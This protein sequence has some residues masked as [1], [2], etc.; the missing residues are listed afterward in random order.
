MFGLFVFLRKHR[1]R[2]QATGFCLLAAIL[3][4]TLG[5]EFY[6]Q[7]RKTTVLN[8]D[9]EIEHRLG[10]RFIIGY[11]EMEELRPIV[12]RGIVG[13]VF[14]TERNAVGKT[15]E[16]LRQEIAGLQ[17]LRRAAGLT[18][19]I[20]AT[21][22]EG[23]IVSRLSPPLELRP[24]LA[25]LVAK[26][27]NKADL[28]AQVETYG[29]QQ[30]KELAQSG[31]TVNFSPVVDLQSN[32]A[33]NRFDF[34]SLINQRAI[35]S[36]PEQTTEVALAYG[37]GLQSQGVRS[38]LKHFPGLGG[39][40]GDTH[41]FSVTLDTPIEGLA[42]RDWVPFQRAA[43]QSKALIM[44]GHVVLSRID[45][46]NPASF[47]RAVVQTIIRGAWKHDG[48]LIT[49]N[50]TMASAYNYGLCEA[51]VKSLNA[52]VDLLLVSYDHE[53]FYEAMYCAVAAYK[54]GVLD[55]EQLE[56]SDKRLERLSIR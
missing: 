47:S 52:G 2:W 39:V 31:V 27:R 45:K 8:R 20:I 3:V 53:K 12:S 40:R 4:I 13:G 38:T 36:S 5:K 29:R 19:L 41:H 49:D 16:Q 15:A 25:E 6:F 33:Q 21:D 23:G 50:L 43:Q 44:L 46:E 11:T 56:R 10:G 28:L 51:T 17:Q 14:V 37:R 7:Y 30:G 54:N 32:N 9:L 24:S 34:H 35:S 26:S 55:E 18:K 1:G 22:Q 42:S 48:I